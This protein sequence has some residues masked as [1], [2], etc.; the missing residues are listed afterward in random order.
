MN[1][2]ACHYCGGI[3]TCLDHIV[4]KALG[5]KRGNNMVPACSGCN[6]SKG[7]LSIESWREVIELKKAARALPDIYWSPK[8]LRYLASI[9]AIKKVPHIFYYEK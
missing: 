1:A 5:G 6:C 2:P 9:G 8:Q 3:A 7:K 4:A